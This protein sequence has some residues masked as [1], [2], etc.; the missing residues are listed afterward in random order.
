MQSTGHSC[1]QVRSRTSMHP[2][3]M[4]YAIWASE[5]IGNRAVWPSD[6]SPRRRDTSPGV[7]IDGETTGAYVISD[8]RHTQALSVTHRTDNFDAWRLIR[9]TKPVEDPCRMQGS[10]RSRANAACSSTAHWSRRPAA[11]AL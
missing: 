10:H 11:R 4:T 2:S 7:R 9:E 1:T 8:P 3:V 5:S 6:H